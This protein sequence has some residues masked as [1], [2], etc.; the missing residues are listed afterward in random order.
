[1]IFFFGFPDVKE[2]IPGF[3]HHSEYFYPPKNQSAKAKAFSLMNLI[4][5]KAKKTF[6]LLEKNKVPQKILSA[7]VFISFQIS[8]RILRF[9]I[10][11]CSSWSSK[12]EFFCSL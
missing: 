10:Q 1:M 2:N 7:K 12:S 3:Q 9:S 6:V 11:S 5:R 4:V 8:A